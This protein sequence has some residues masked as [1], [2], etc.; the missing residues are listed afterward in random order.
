[1]IDNIVGD[2]LTSYA[3]VFASWDVFLFCYLLRPPGSPDLCLPGL[4]SVLLVWYTSFPSIYYN[5]CSYPYFCR[6]RQCIGDYRSCHNWSASMRP[7]FNAIKYST[8]FPAI[9]LSVLIVHPASNSVWRTWW[10]VAVSINTIYSILWDVLIDWDLGYISTAGKYPILLRPNLLLKDSSIYYGSILLNALCRASWTIRVI[11][12]AFYSR[13]HAMV[14]LLESSHAIFLFQLIEI[15]RR[16]L[17][18]VL[19][20]ESYQVQQSAE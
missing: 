12:S 13:D 5:S 18:L 17:W 10:I 4:L 14:A 19:R 2:V 20:I 16:F 15:S 7:L 11:T 9:Y 1:M 8:S 3:K 6:L